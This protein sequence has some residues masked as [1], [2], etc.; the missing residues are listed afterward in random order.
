[1]G[2]LYHTFLYQPLLNALVVLYQTIAFEDL[3]VAIII[4][5]IITRLIFMP[6]F[7]KA[8][9]QQAIIQKLKPELEKIDKQYEGNLEEKG[10]AQM[11]LYKEHKINPFSMIFTLFI[12]LLILIPLF[13]IFHAVPG[14][15]N[16]QD[17]YPFIRLPEVFHHSFLGLIDLQGQSLVL[18]VIASVLQFAQT[19][20]SFS[21]QKNV[22]KIAQQMAFVG[23]AIIIIFLWAAPAAVWLYLVASNTFSVIQQM[24]VNRQFREEKEEQNNEKK[25]QSS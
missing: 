18:I 19:K 23:P 2:F 10:R 12:Q 4:L 6:L 20:L 3:G 25:D 1:M 5:T 15:L 16:A 21:I 14:S 8:M 22:N 17:M 13:Q 9:K 11:A 24:I 7:Q